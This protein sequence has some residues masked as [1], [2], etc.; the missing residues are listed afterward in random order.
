[1]QAPRRIG[2]P[3]SI[4]ILGSTMILATCS[5][6]VT[7]LDTC[8]RPSSCNNDALLL[9]KMSAP[10]TR[11]RPNSIG[12]V[13]ATSRWHHALAGGAASSGM[14]GT[15]ESSRKAG[16]IWAWHNVNGSAATIGCGELLSLASPR[17]F[18]GSLACSVGYGRRSDAHAV[19]SG[20]HTIIGHHPG[21]DAGRCNEIFLEAES[22]GCGADEDRRKQQE[23]VAG[24]SEVQMLK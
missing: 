16:G 11:A 21:N 2:Q 5:R 23:E 15:F 6:T 1:M 8:V 17:A 19:C 20:S 24:A 18:L 4:D 13:R 7:W 14:R 9:L 12:L 10:G 3:P 22:H